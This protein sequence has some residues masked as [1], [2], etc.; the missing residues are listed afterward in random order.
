MNNFITTTKAIAAISFIF[1]TILFAL[2]ISFR[3]SHM[4]I[5]PGFIFVIVAIILNTISFL[6]LL[7][8]LLGNPKEKLE[9]IKACGIVLL[10]I[11]IAI[12]Y[13]IIIINIDFST[14]F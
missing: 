2:Q 1:G 14:Q 4:F 3:H 7:F 5:Y 10:N 13:F 12:L 11:P 6:G 8:Y 9:I